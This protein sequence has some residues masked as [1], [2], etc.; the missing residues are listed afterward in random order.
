MPVDSLLKVDGKQ[1]WMSHISHLFPHMAEK[2]EGRSEG[3]GKGPTLSESGFICPQTETETFHRGIGGTVQMY[4]LY[5]KRRTSKA[6]CIFYR[7]WQPEKLL[8]TNSWA[9]VRVHCIRPLSSHV[10]CRV[11]HGC[12]DDLCKG[13]DEVLPV[14]LE[15]QL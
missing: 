3:S 4:M 14:R 6:T 15:Y 13:R 10:R 9:S 8:A 12:L 7:V 2:R 1:H 5:V 11:S